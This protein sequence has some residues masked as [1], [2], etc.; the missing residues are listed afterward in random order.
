M[1]RLWRW[2]K[3]N[4]RL[5]VRASMAVFGT[6]IIVKL[7][8]AGGLMGLLQALLVPLGAMTVTGSFMVLGGGYYLLKSGRMM[9]AITMATVGTLCF[10]VG[11]SILGIALEA[12]ILVAPLS[13][14]L[15]IWGAAIEGVYALGDAVKEDSHRDRVR[16]VEEK[17]REARLKGRAEMEDNISSGTPLPDLA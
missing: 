4:F 2:I 1:R 9:H 7:V 13:V 12:A 6:A 5:L 15:L 3:S 8:V 17:L 10:A 14:D 11:C 16:A